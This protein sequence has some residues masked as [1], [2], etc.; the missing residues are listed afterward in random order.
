MLGVTLQIWSYQRGKF[1]FYPI[2]FQFFTIKGYGITFEFGTTEVFAMEWAGLWNGRIVNCFSV[3]EKL[4][5]KVVKALRRAD[6]GVTHAAI[7]MLCALMQVS[8]CRL[9]FINSNPLM[10]TGFY[11]LLKTVWVNVL[12]SPDLGTHRYQCSLSM[13]MKTDRSISMVCM[14]G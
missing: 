1:S 7:E 4:G 5:K 8:D 3:R 6:T 14:P 10:C 9:D 13:L 11:L 12:K 2:Q